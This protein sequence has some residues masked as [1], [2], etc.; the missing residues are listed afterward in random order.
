MRFTAILASFALVAN[1]GANSFSAVPSATSFN[2]PIKSLG[3]TKLYSSAS[4][5][6][7]ASSFGEAND[8]INYGPGELSELFIIIYYT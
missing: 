3:S 5:A 1:H 6:S 8:S 7:D 4:I 2:S